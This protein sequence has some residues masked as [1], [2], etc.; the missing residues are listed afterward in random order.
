MYI[1]LIIVL[2][3][4]LFFPFHFRF[5]LFVIDQTKLFFN[6]IYGLDM[7]MPF[8]WIHING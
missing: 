7:G 8:S 5:L 4:I 1:K 2:D 3:L 6:H